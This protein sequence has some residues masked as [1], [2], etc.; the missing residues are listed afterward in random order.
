MAE[1]S[2]TSRMALWPTLK[3]KLGDAKKKTTRKKQKKQNP[4]ASQGLEKF[5]LLM[6]EL[7][8]K[9]SSLVDKT[10]NSV[11][12]VRYLSRSAQEWTASTIAR[13][14]SRRREKD[15]SPKASEILL[16]QQSPPLPDLHSKETAEIETVDFSH[17]FSF[18]DP[19]TSHSYEFESEVSVVGDLRRD[20]D[21]V[22]A[23]AEITRE[24]CEELKEREE[25]GCSGKMETSGL[26]AKSARLIRTGRR[27]LLEKGWARTPNSAVALLV[28]LSAC[29]VARVT[30]IGNSFF[31]LLTV[32]LVFR[33]Q[34][35]KFYADFLQSL[36]TRHIVPHLSIR[37][38]RGLALLPLARRKRSPELVANPQTSLPSKHEQSES[39]C[40]RKPNPGFSF[41][42]V[43]ESSSLASHDWPTVAVPH[44]RTEA[45]EINPSAPSNIRTSSSTRRLVRKLSSKLKAKMSKSS[46]P[47]SPDSVDSC[48]S[49]SS[50]TSPRKGSKFSFARRD[51]EKEASS[52]DGW[53]DDEAFADSAS[54]SKKRCI[55]GKKCSFRK[56]KIPEPSTTIRRSPLGRNFSAKLMEATSS[57]EITSSLPDARNS[58]AVFDTG[59]KNFDLWLLMGLLVA[60]L[61][62]LVSRLSAVVATSFLFLLLSH[63]HK[64]SSKYRMPRREAARPLHRSSGYGGRFDSPSR[65]EAPSNEFY[66]RGGG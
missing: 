51:K 12:A 28:A 4:F 42:V 48:H 65:E 8:A 64:E 59:R 56:E 3:K 47:G 46:T 53:P 2:S 26:P 54:S 19:G 35:G 17:S 52:D 10:G 37:V 20:T 40:E 43:P 7:Q 55:L 57:A 15:T 5:A 30:K 24:P 21:A 31:E 33:W 49:H 36:V 38:P 50:G 62:L 29:V 22:S 11:S 45:P 61:F 1:N 13:T 23:M 32:D 27:L 58:P 6:A 9:K 63:A 34:K 41:P 16:L 44:L 18:P 39:V 60:L 66:R 14:A 25:V